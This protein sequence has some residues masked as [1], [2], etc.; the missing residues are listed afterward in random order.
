LVIYRFLDLRDA[1]KMKHIK[2]SLLLFVLL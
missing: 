1:R 2:M